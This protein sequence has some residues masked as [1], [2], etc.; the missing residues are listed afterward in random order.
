[1]DEYFHHA[2]S[3]SSIEC[4]EC[5]GVAEK[6]IA[7]AS[8]VV[9]GQQED[10]TKLQKLLREDRQKIAKG[11]EDFISNLTG[12]PQKVPTHSGTKHLD[13]VPADKRKI[14]RRKAS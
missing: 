12:D 6:G 7:R 8:V 1:M 2:N 11:D 9:K 5:G 14:K 4:S 3:P 10:V 13:D